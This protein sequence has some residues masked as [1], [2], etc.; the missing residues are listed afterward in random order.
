MTMRAAIAIAPPNPSAA[1]LGHVAKYL[2]AA[3]GVRNDAIRAAQTRGAL[4]RIQA[5]LKSIPI[6][7]T[8]DPDF[9]SVLSDQRIAS[10]AFIESLAGQSIF[11]TM[12]ADRAI[13]RVPL[14][15]FLGLLVTGSTG[16]IVDEGQTVGGSRLTLSGGNKVPVIKG[17][18]FV[19]L[20]KEVARSETA[21][22]SEL[23]NSELRKAVTAVVD[24]KFTTIAMTGAPSIASSGSSDSDLTNDIQALLAAV[25][26]A[27][28]K[29]YFAAAANVANRM[30]IADKRG[31]MTPQGGAFLG[32]P[33]L[34]SATVSAGTLRLFDA[35]GF[36]GDFEGVGIDSSNVATLDLGDPPDS[37]TSAATTLISLFQS[38]LSAVKATAYFGA[39]KIRTAAAAE[40]TGIG[41]SPDSPA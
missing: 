34:V 22:A 8:D 15:Q 36:A 23:V 30:A 13:R 35:A 27:G 32:V 12:V 37:P 10:D 1:V 28:S 9:G 26:V 20:S 11:S 40:L 6:G 33:T 3:D 7:T 21:A 19:V 29:L 14:N 25:N 4:P 18:A 38:G 17:Q 5:V 24:Q 16:G 41:N 39:K 31:E 2:L